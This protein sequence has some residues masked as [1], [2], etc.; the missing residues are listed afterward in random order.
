MLHYKCCR[1]PKE[2]PRILSRQRTRLSYFCM[3]HQFEQFPLHWTP[4]PLSPHLNERLTPQHTSLMDTRNY[5]HLRLSVQWAEAKTEQRC[6]PVHGTATVPRCQSHFST[7]YFDSRFVFIH[8]MDKKLENTL[9]RLLVL[10]LI[11]HN[12]TNSVLLQ[13]VLQHDYIQCIRC[14]LLLVKLKRESMVM[15]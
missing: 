14:S 7:W 1:F 12:N 9:S 11:N 10:Y 3:S 5:A 15:V 13:A 6:V 8:G 2:L 4:A